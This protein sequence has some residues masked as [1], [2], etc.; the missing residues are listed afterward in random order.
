[1]VAETIGLTGT[2]NYPVVVAYAVLAFTG[3]AVIGGALAASGLVPR[4]VGWATVLWNLSWLVGLVLANPQDVYFPVLH[5]VQ[6]GAASVLAVR[7]VAWWCDDQV[8][9]LGWAS[10]AR[11]SKGD[12][13]DLHDG[14]SGRS[15]GHHVARPR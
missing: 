7:L 8:A 5:L 12:G 3:Q 14:G 6:T 15:E 1:M 9:A 13:L 4:W 2:R 10:V 11:G